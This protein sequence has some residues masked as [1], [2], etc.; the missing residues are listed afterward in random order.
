MSVDSAASQK[1]IEDLVDQLDTRLDEIVNLMVESYA[2]NIPNYRD[3]PPDVA[4]DIREGA[5][6]S[7]IVGAA[8]LRGETTGEAVRD[9]L[10]DLGRR[11]ALQGL[12]LPDVINAFMVGTRTFWTEIVKVAPKD[13]QERADVLSHVMTST[14]DLLQN[15]TATVSAGWREVDDLRIVDEEHDYRTVVEMMA[16]IR[17][18]DAEHPHRAARR[19][20]DVEKAAWCLVTEHEDYGAEVVRDLRRRFPEAPIAPSGELLIAFLPDEQT[21]DPIKNCQCGLAAASDPAIAF[22][23][24]RS[25][26]KVAVHLERDTV[27]YDEVVPLALVL[28]ASPEERSAFVAAQLGPVLDDPLGAELLTSLEAFYAT[29]QSVAAAARHLHVHRHTLE[30]R[31]GRLET[32]LQ[33]DLRASGPRLLLERALSLRDEP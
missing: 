23:R 7:I 15:A 9:P 10:R 21:P 28:D 13:P 1:A 31:L 16:G 18:H 4:Q 25:A 33:T 8:I 30:Y 24:A 27:V 22:K 32:L 3:A 6:A 20:I 12:P 11:R 14:L 26:H 19:G 2:A 5:R 29:G 17:P